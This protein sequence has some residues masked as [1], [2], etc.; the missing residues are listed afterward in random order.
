MSLAEVTTIYPS[1]FR[2]PVPML[3]NLADAIESGKYGDVGCVAVSLLG[4]EMY[5][6]GWG[7]DSESPSVHLM[8]CAG[9]RYLE[10]GLLDH[11][12]PVA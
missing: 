8:L 3:R 10:Q 11:G 12:K 7:R 2:D 9:A 1:N 6:F 5:V 4:D